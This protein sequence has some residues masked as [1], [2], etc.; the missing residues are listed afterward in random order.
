MQK[1]KPLTRAC[2]SPAV[3]EANPASAIPISIKTGHGLMYNAATDDNLSPSAPPCGQAYN[4]SALRISVDRGKFSKITKLIVVWLKFIY[5]TRINITF[6]RGCFFESFQEDNEYP[7]ISHSRGIGEG[8][9]AE[10][11]GQ[12]RIVLRNGGT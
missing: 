9:T 5:N 12:T 10:G 6:E 4:I 1:A 8:K 7:T 11:R 2:Q 3:R